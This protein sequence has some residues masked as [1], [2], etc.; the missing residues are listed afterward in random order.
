MI[1][2]EASESDV[3][4]NLQIGAC[5]IAF[6]SDLEISEE[7]YQ[8][9][10]VTQEGFRA[11]MARK[12]W[13]FGD[14][15]G[16]TLSELRDIPLVMNKPE[17]M[18]FDLSRNACLANGFEPDVRFMSSRQSG[19]MEYLSAHP[20]CYVGLSRVV[21]KNETKSVRSEPIV[22]HPPVNFLFCWDNNTA[23]PAL[24]KF[25]SFAQERMPSLFSS[26]HPSD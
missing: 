13:A 21:L 25:V 23:T 9:L 1:L 18:L 4:T 5:D 2:N 12:Y 10:F 3:Y 26:L 20:Y 17:S 16:V 15:G 14:S 19:I 11:A 24:R 6:C 8:T 22:D 7:K